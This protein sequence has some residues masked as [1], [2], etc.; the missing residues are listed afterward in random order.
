[1]PRK[2]KTTKYGGKT[3]KHKT[4]KAAKKYSAKMKKKKKY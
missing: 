3:K 4:A 2:G 1:M